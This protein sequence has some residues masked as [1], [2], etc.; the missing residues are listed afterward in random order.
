MS[1]T[2]VQ[3]KTQA[4]QCQINM[5]T[6]DQDKLTSIKC[7]TNPQHNT[8]DKTVAMIML[9]QQKNFTVH[10]SSNGTLRCSKNFWGV[11]AKNYNNWG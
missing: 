8:P 9:T 7:V 1:S 11:Y 2:N 5:A 10:Q 3:A 4:T 6:K